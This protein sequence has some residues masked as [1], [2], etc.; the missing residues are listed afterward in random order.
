VGTIGLTVNSKNVAQGANT[1]SITSADAVSTIATP[2][3]P[4]A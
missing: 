1:S 2:P 3:P 4:S